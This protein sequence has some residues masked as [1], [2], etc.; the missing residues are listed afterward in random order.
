MGLQSDTSGSSD[1]MHMVEYEIE[2]SEPAT[3]AVVRAMAAAADIP[4]EKLPALYDSIEPEA[5]NQLLAPEINGRPRADVTVEFT[6]YG[7]TVRVDGKTVR[8]YSFKL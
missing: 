2:E 3:N 8:F 5:L 1:E 7:K 4:V 6:Y